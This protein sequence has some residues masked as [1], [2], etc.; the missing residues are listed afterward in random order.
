VECIIIILVQIPFAGRYKN[1]RSQISIGETGYNYK[2]AGS[3]RNTG[4]CA[5]HWHSKILES[6]VYEVLDG[7]RIQPH[8]SAEILPGCK[9]KVKR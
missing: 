1:V 2:H 5:C 7:V 6:K 8:A 4:T 9:F 3:F